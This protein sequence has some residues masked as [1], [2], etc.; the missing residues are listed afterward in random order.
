MAPDGQS[1]GACAPA[2]LCSRHVWPPPSF[3]RCQQDHAGVLDPAGLA[4]PNSTPSWNVAPTD[5]LSL[6]CETNKPQD[7]RDHYRTPTR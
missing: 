2:P 5:A 6:L 1:L 3:H 7:A 4:N